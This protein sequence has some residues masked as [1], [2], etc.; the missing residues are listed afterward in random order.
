M[1]SSPCATQKAKSWCMR[2]I[3]FLVNFKCNL[4]AGFELFSFSV[5][6]IPV[7]FEATTDCSLK[8]NIWQNASS[9]GW[10]VIEIKVLWLP[11]LQAEHM[12]FNLKIL[13]ILRVCCLSSYGN[14]V[15]KGGLWLSWV[16]YEASCADDTHIYPSWEFIILISPVCDA[17]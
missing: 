7:S 15:N 10:N 9:R 3:T 17:N 16:M 8:N 14:E 4:C 12:S 5:S 2:E 6:L 1:S 13:L 11:H